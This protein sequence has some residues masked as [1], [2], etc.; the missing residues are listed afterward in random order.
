MIIYWPIG[1]LEE[2]DPFWGG[3]QHTYDSVTR[4]EEVEDCFRCW[5]VSYNMKFKKLLV[6]V[7]NLDLEHDDPNYSHTYEVNGDLTYKGSLG[8]GEFIFKG[9]L[10]D[11][12]N[13][14][15]YI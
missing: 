8:K 12:V 6:D 13:R 15:E 3:T 9:T 11:E 2:P 5:M 1:V 10:G 7:D 4:W 14:S